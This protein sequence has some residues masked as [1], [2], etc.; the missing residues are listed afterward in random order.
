VSRVYTLQTA[1]PGN[2]FGAPSVGLVENGRSANDRKLL[3]MRENALKR[4]AAWSCGGAGRR[5]L[6][7]VDRNRHAKALGFDGPMANSLDAYPTQTSC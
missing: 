7:P 1:E 3:L 6:V 4:I 2:A 5:D